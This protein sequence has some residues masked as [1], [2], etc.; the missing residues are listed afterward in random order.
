MRAVADE[1]TETIL[2]G[3]IQRV[4]L[5]DARTLV[6]E[7]FAHGTRHHLLIS[8][9]PQS[10]RIH[11]VPARLTADAER[12]TPFLLLLRKHVRGGRIVAV[13]QPP[14]ERTLAVSIVKAYPLVKDRTP[15]EEF[16]E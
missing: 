15:V 7:V 9:H 4:G 2:G 16:A 8:N 1:L 11:L 3:R 6:L 14:L 13:A 12:V 5:V 10:A